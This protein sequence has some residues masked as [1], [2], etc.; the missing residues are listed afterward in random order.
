MLN[1]RLYVQKN[2]EKKHSFEGKKYTLGS[3]ACLRSK[4]AAG[5]LDVQR[6][7]GRPPG[8]GGHLL[9][10]DPAFYTAWASAAR[11]TMLIAFL[12]QVHSQIPQPQ[13]NSG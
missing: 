5:R 2:S 3:Y 9:R 13:H 4:K 7:S 8:A 10:D 6:R 11:G 1:L 12:G